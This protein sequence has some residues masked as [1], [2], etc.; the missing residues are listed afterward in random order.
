MEDININ[1][2]EFEKIIA[3]EFAWQKKTKIE[4][5]HNYISDILFRGHAKK[6]WKL[7]TTLERFVEK[8]KCI[9][10]SFSWKDYHRILH[11]VN[12]IVSSYTENKYEIKEFS[13]HTSWAVPPSYDFMI[14]LRHHGFPS[15]LLDW[16]MSPY[17]AAFF[18][19]SDADEEEDVAIFFYREYLGVG[20]GGWAER[21]KINSLGPYVKTH[22]RHHKQQCQY[23]ICIQQKDAD[24]RKSHLYVC[25]E[26]AEF[27]EDQDFMRKFVL[28]GKQRKEVLEKL[29]IMNINAYSLFG[30]EESL[31]S[32]L[33]YKEIEK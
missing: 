23:T 12:P 20:K 10:K 2:Q 25:H 28:P 16:S 3:D 9:K 1:W 15:P 29:N 19:F 27:Q 8:K 13:E 17:V 5:P 11:S 24:D 21:I 26:D 30:N 7:E 18:A 4:K 32:M 6:E 22:V 14:Y 31:M 33:A